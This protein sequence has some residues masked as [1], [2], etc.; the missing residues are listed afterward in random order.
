METVSRSGLLL[1][2]RTALK[3]VRSG[4]VPVPRSGP[5]S[6][7]GKTKSKSRMGLRA[8]A[9]NIENHR[10]GPTHEKNRQPKC[11][12]V[13]ETHL[14]ARKPRDRRTGRESRITHANTSREATKAQAPQARATGMGSWENRVE[15]SESRN[16]NQNAI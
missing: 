8:I 11:L 14:E 13:R 10:Q 5:A 15:K 4:P 12:N 16:W 7:G 6:L 9:D 3:S 1:W 2:D